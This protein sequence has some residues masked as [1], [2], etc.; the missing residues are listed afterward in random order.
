MNFLINRV[1]FHGGREPNRGQLC[2]YLVLFLLNLIVVSV[3]VPL[4]AHAFTSAIAREGIRLVAA[5]L[6]T[7]AALLPLNA[8]A[9][10]RWVFLTPADHVEGDTSG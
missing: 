1:V 8:L 6:L 7:T 4:L 9:Y 2:R 3:V 5:K 10:H